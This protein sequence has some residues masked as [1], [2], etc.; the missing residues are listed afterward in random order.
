MRRISEPLLRFR[1]CHGPKSMGPLCVEAG[2]IVGESA[3]RPRTADNR[4]GTS[5]AEA[6]CPFSGGFLCRVGVSPH[7]APSHISCDRE[8][9]LR[10]GNEPDRKSLWRGAVL[11][12]SAIYNFGMMPGSFFGHF[13]MVASSTFRCWATN[14]GGVCVSQLVS[15]ISS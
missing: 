2:R 3:G 7:S 11:L 8:V 10:R 15:E 6:A 1:S 4:D 9:D 13:A 14:A 12:N 5:G